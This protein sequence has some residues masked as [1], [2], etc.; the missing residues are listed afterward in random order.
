MAGSL[1]RLLC[2]SS[3]NCGQLALLGALVKDLSNSQAA[4]AQRADLAQS[5]AADQQSL[6]GL[7]GLVS[8]QLDELALLDLLAAAQQRLPRRDTRALEGSGELADISGGIST[9]GLK[10]VA[11]TPRI[12]R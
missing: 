8:Q 3:Q 10:R 7:G 5:P 4:G 1:E 12:G 6:D 11:F 2:S 9:S